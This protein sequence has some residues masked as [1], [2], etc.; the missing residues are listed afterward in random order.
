MP[1]YLFNT[2]DDSPLDVNGTQLSDIAEARCEAVTRAGRL[3][4]DAGGKYWKRQELCM[5]VADG[6]GLTL[7]SLHFFGTDAAAVLLEPRI[8]VC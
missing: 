6:D 5:S 3:I 2:N 1:Q 4:C 7:F 8:Q